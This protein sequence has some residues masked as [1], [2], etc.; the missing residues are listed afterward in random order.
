MTPVTSMMTETFRFDH[1]V[2]TGPSFFDVRPVALTFSRHPRVHFD[3]PGWGLG[4]IGDTMEIFDSNGDVQ[5]YVPVS[6]RISAFLKTYSPDQGYGIL[7]DHHVL[8]E[9]ENLVKFKATLVSSGGAVLAQA[10]AVREITALT[11]SHRVWECGETAALQR[12]MSRLGFGSEN[13]FSDELNDMGTSAVSSPSSVTTTETDESEAVESAPET[14][15][16]NDDVSEQNDGADDT[17]DADGAD[18]A[19]GVVASS[20]Q[21][22]SSTTQSKSGGGGSKKKQQAK[23]DQPSE[24]LLRQIRHLAG[25]A[26]VEVPD[27][28]DKGEAKAF[29]QNL[30][31]DA[32]S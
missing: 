1:E 5:E 17:H 7:S 29:L 26:R 11:V 6:E 22:T 9:S 32:S 25:L 2:M 16:E 20:N 31:Q 8:F 27:F 24:S 21:T 30:R 28:A 12:L 13:L 15:S 19:D 3:Q 18:D 4:F 23:A 14:S 10:S